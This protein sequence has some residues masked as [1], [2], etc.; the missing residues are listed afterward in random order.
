MR[1]GTT[2][3]LALL[4]AADALHASAVRAT[5]LRGTALRSRAP[6]P[7]AKLFSRYELDFTSRDH[8]VGEFGLQGHLVGLAPQ[9]DTFILLFVAFLVARAHCLPMPD[10]AFAAAFPAYLG[11]ANYL[12]FDLAMTRLYSEGG[13]TLPKRY[14]PLLR[15]G[16]G[17][18][19]KRYV[20]TTA[21]LGL[22]LPLPIVFLAPRS[23][24][25]AA[26]PHLFLHACQCACEG[27]TA[28]S[29]FSALLRLAVPI[30]FN[31]YRLGV[32]RTWCAAAIC[33]AR[34]GAA[35]A[36]WAWPALALALANFVVWTYHLFIFLLLRAAP[37]YFDAEEF[38][39]PP[40]TWH[41]GLL[42]MVTRTAA[43]ERAPPPAAAPAPAAPTATVA[44]WYDSGQR[45]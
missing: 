25:L 36:V 1:V 45:L 44:S 31:A 27:M 16:R 43:E 32:L 19:L 11:F 39:T 12:R 9:K 29:H 35:P 10:I 34:A 30:G 3:L 5:A 21:L 4:S 8:S 7:A 41:F 18:W 23:I 37:Q 15:E 14:K 38:P 22:V 42:P 20:L 26:A 2:G 17:V 33:T 28:H 6:P 13:T 24:G 40:T